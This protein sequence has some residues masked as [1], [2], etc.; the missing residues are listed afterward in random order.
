MTIQAPGNARKLDTSISDAANSKIITGYQLTRADSSQ[1]IA[2]SLGLLIL[3]II[4]AVAF[5]QNADANTVELHDNLNSYASSEVDDRV[6]TGT[7]WLRHSDGAVQAPLLNS[8]VDAVVSGI[9]AKV[10]LF[11]EFQNLSSHL[12]D[13]RYVFPLP[14]SAA[15]KAVRINIGDR[16]I[17]SVI[18]EKQQAEQIFEQAKVSGHTTSLI[19]QK[20]ENLF[21]I[22][23]ANIEGNAKIH[24]EVDYIETV[25][26]VDNVY[27]LVLPLT[28]IPRY[29]NTLVAES[30][31]NILTRPQLKATRAN[32]LKTH[33]FDINLLLVTDLQLGELTSP[34]HEIVYTPVTEGY[35]INLTRQALM[36]RDFELRWSWQVPFRPASSVYTE[37]IDDT[38]YMLGLVN[39]PSERNP[40][41]RKSANNYL[42]RELVI[43]VDTSGS[44]DGAPIRTAKNALQAAINGLDAGDYFNLVRFSTD[45]DSLFS[46]SQPVTAKNV[47]QARRYINSLDA[48]GG[49]EMLE[50]VEFAL[51]T[52]RSPQHTLKQI[53]FITDGAIGYENHV[54]NHVA[55]HLG[56][57]RLF[58]VG[59]GQAPNRDLMKKLAV[60]GRG[61]HTF[62]RDIN[63]VE[64]QMNRLFRGI[65]RP[66]MRD[67]EIEWL[68]EPADMAQESLRDLHDG[69]PL[70]F[71]A[72]LHPGTLGFIVSGTL[73][74]QPWQETVYFQ[75][76]SGTE[77]RAKNAANPVEPFDQSGI[78]TIWARQRIS[79]LLARYNALPSIP[80]NQ[81]SLTGITLSEP[82][83]THFATRQNIKHRVTKLGITHK[84]LTPFTAFVAVDNTK[85]N[86]RSANTPA[87]EVANLV[88]AGNLQ[89]IPMPQTATAIDLFKLISFISFLIALIAGLCLFYLEKHSFSSVSS[90]ECGA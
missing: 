21:S 39:P 60:A 83:N 79:N 42:S 36:D 63:A 24:V 64:S 46:A 37:T 34:S 55:N 17:E 44:M 38:V 11:Q 49:T 80:A 47:H 69:E 76:R 27:A 59:I 54:T 62:I 61:T 66:V 31:K 4:L 2:R 70:L 74:D 82:K 52:E 67:I 28:F 88:P 30:D 14:G 1:L 85:I 13:G 19:K 12:I 51:D 65:E 33:T 40:T 77:I 16:V 86:E 87:T 43:V 56:R 26:V 18:R 32:Q 73:A 53:V 84:L 81:L 3:Q 29:T 78:A 90:T 9:L 7:L 15:V 22:N 71:A 75:Q 58:T 45:T 25:T 72:K 41:T 48:G 20:R 57:A 35:Q 50:A 23:L 68:G 6:E 8:K 5:M 89:I 10:T